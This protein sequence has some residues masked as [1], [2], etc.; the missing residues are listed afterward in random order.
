MSFPHQKKEQHQ[1]I[2]TKPM[3]VKA[4]EHIQTLPILFVIY[5]VSIATQS[6]YN[7]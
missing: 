5:V 1:K 7:E 6:P 4:N 2:K 3:M